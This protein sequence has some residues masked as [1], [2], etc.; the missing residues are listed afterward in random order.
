MP[1]LVE[2]GPVL[3]DK[4]IFLFCQCIFAISFLSLLVKGRD[5]SFEEISELPYSNLRTV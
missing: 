1:D 3:L 5:P 2:I 4:K